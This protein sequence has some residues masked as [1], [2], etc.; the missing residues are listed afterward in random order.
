MNASAHEKWKDIPG[1]DGRYQASTRS[2]YR[3]TNCTRAYA[4]ALRTLN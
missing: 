3:P 2:G 4:D 1:F